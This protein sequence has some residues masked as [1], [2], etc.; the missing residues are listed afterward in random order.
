MPSRIRERKIPRPN[1]PVIDEPHPVPGALKESQNAFGTNSACLR[2][3]RFA[4]SNARVV[5]TASLGRSF[6]VWFRLV[7]E[8]EIVPLSGWREKTTVPWPQASGRLGI[9]NEFVDDGGKDLVS[10]EARLAAAAISGPGKG[11][12]GS[13]W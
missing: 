10:M 11:C 13:R 6:V 9:K 7:D 3:N 1:S 2:P 4:H 8:N 5:T 12:G